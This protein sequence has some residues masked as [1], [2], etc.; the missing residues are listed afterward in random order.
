MLYPQTLQPVC[1]KQCFVPWQQPGRSTVLLLR[2]FFFLCKKTNKCIRNMS[3]HLSAPWE[4][5]TSVLTHFSNC[6][7]YIHFIHPGL[8][9]PFQRTANPLLLSPFMNRQKSNKR[10]ETLILKKVICARKSQ[11]SKNCP[12]DIKPYCHMHHNKQWQ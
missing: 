3:C 6:H 12:S 2:T 5:E 11:L 9:S 1:F 8:S 4:T 10:V 7:K